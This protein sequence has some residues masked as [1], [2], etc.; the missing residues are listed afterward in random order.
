M[1][2]AASLLSELVHLSMFT[3]VKTGLDLLTA[4]N[5]GTFCTVS[6]LL[7]HFIMYP[8]GL[9]CNFAFSHYYLALMLFS[10]VE[11]PVVFDSI[12]LR[13]TSMSLSTRQ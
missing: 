13:L 6:V 9:R 7:F 10:F 1:A 12:S 2:E 3:H 5:D 11:T 4:F 8:A